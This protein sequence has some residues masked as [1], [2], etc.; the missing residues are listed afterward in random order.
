MTV[1]VSYP[2]A[3]QFRLFPG[4]RMTPAANSFRA[5][6]WIILILLVAAILRIWGLNAHSLEHDELSSWRRANYPTLAESLEKG[7]LVDNHPPLWP[8]LQFYNMKL[9]GEEPWQLRWHS[10]LFGLLSVWMAFLIG[11]RLYGTNHA[12]AVAGMMA[13]L[14][15][16]VYYSNEARM[17]SLLV[18]NVLLSMHAWLLV[19]ARFRDKQPVPFVNGLYLF[20]A[21]SLTVYTHFF[22]IL[23][24]ALL[25]FSSGLYLLFSGRAKRILTLLAIFVPVVLV[26]LPYVPYVLA[27]TGREW[28]A[29]PPSL[30]WYPRFLAWLMN[31]S[32]L[33]IVP[34][35]LIF[36][37]ALWFVIRDARARKRGVS[38]PEVRRLS[39]SDWI[40]LAWM[41]GPYLAAAVQSYLSTPVVFERNLLVSMPG[42]YLGFTRAVEMLVPEPS[43]YRRAMLVIVLIFLAH[44]LFINR[45]HTTPQRHQ[46]REA[47]ALVAERMADANPD[48]VMVIGSRGFPD[49]FNY[50]L[51][52]YHSPVLVEFST[53]DLF[54]A[55]TLAPIFDSLQA[56]GELPPTVVQMIRDDSF[57]RNDEEWF[58][59]YGYHVTW[60]ER[61]HKMHVWRYD[62]E[63][64]STVDRPPSGT[65]EP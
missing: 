30:I 15:A 33:L 45:Y 2:Q 41:L 17:Y 29:D 62:L 7:I 50:Y 64:D 14:W 36:G 31:K 61:L 16:P 13:V 32:W 1:R 35:G 58:A 20:A 28:I 10:A 37:A 18:L 59:G 25:G 34:V 12:L 46:F 51:E 44:T 11:K 26:F 38:T 42:V 65:L 63:R 23:F 43:K 3:N 8:V 49:Y 54:P 21:S 40:V 19:N 4:V 60:Y 39:D 48:S 52:R 6:R 27:A 53:H 24:I 56:N 9:V 5:S 55:D 57:K 22:G 47:G